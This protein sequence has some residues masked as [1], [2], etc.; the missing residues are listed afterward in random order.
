ML[1]SLFCCE[2][3]SSPRRPLKKIWMSS[4]SP[5]WSTATRRRWTRGSVCVFSFFYPLTSQSE[6]LCHTRTY[7]VTYVH[8]HTHVT[9]IHSELNMSHITSSTSLSPRRPI[10]FDF[11]F[12]P[13]SPAFLH[14]CFAF[15][16]GPRSP[17]LSLSVSQLSFFAWQLLWKY[18]VAEIQI[19]WVTNWA[20]AP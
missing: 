12:F 20:I 14:L 4:F 10:T 6:C 5:C 2:S 8:T 15:S 18:N 3:R 19:M 7:A 11:S 13:V 16:F 17:P 9:A 1:Y